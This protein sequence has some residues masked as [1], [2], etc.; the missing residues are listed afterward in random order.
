VWLLAALVSAQVLL[1]VEAWIPKFSAARLPE[2]VLL[3]P[4]QAGVRTLHVL[5][6]S[7]LLAAA[8]VWV[9]Q[10]RR[11]SASAAQSLGPAARLEG[12]A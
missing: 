3:R 8:V 7:W 10:T 12:A 2:T 11:R 1:G 4:G 6:G 9:L 5:V